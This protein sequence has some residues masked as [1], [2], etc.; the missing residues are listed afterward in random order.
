MPVTTKAPLGADTLNRKWY[1][2][3][4]TGTYETPTWVSVFGIMELKALQEATTQDSSDFDGEGWKSETVTAQT[5]GLEGKLRR[6]VTTADPEAY[7][8]GQELIRLAS[9]EM[10]PLNTL[11]IRFYEHT[12]GGPQVEAYRGRVGCSW[13]PEGGGMDA[14]DTVAFK[15]SGQG[16]RTAIVHPAA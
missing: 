15:L 9:I 2:D 14:L 16:K 6:G 5:W 11:D 7:D 1:V 3:I 4:N 10:G 12:P 8:P 13:T